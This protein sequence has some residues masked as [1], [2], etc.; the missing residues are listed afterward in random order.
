MSEKN[1]AEQFLS[2]EALVLNQHWLEQAGSAL[3]PKHC[4]LAVKRYDPFAA[5]FP[6][7]D[8]PTLR[9]AVPKRQREFAA[10]R[11]A[12]AAALLKLG[13]ANQRI[14]VGPDRNPVWPAGVVGSIT[15]TAG[16]AVAVVAR[17]AE[18]AGLGIDLELNEALT[19]ELWP[20][21]LRP[22]EI[23]W[24]RTQ[25]LPKQLCGATAIFCAKEAF[26]KLHYPLTQQWLEFLDAEVIIMDREN[27][28]IV[29]CGVSSLA[30]KLSQTEFAGRYAMSDK[31]IVS[32]ML[33]PQPLR[34]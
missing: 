20:S 16:L 30:G 12:A 6:V 1:E 15:H 23:D 21:V 10:G 24:V 2:G 34:K 31:F 25:P 8:E 13:I 19:P 27:Q 7:Q 22:A 4:A 3:F 18:V 9:N 26:Y 11:T 17:Q 29:T 28:F 33:L 14:P 32:A 5:P